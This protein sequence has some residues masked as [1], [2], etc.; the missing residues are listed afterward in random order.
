MR[1]LLIKIMG[2][3]GCGAETMQTIRVEQHTSAQPG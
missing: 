1:S 3:V 2:L